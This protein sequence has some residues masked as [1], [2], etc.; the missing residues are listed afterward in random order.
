M[1]NAQV[2]IGVTG[3]GGGEPSFIRAMGEGLSSARERC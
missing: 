3:H 2:G 1:S